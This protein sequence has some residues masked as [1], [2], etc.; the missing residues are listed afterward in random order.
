MKT[1]YILTYHCAGNVGA[2]LQCYALSTTIEKMGYFPKVIDFRPSKVISPSVERLFW[3]KKNM[4]SIKRFQWYFL[5]DLRYFKRILKYCWRKKNHYL[6]FKGNTSSAFC[7]FMTKKLHLT[8]KVYYDFRELESFAYTNDIFIVGSDQ[9][10]NPILSDAPQVYLLDFVKVGK[11]NAYGASFGTKSIDEH[12]GHHLKSSLS[13]Y[14]IISVRENSG[15]GIVRSA[16]EKLATCVVDPVFL[17]DKNDWI[18]LTY[19]VPIS[20]PFIFVYRTEENPLFQ[21]EIDKLRNINPQLKIVQFDSF[22]GNLNSDYIIPR[23]GPLDFISY[24]FASSYVLTNSF[25]GSA[26]SII[27]RKSAVIIPH[28]FYNER[29]DSLMDTIGIRNNTDGIYLLKEKGYDFFL[30]K[31]IDYSLALIRDIC[32]E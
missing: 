10:W 24:L 19:K 11:K 12:F 1:I 7:D 9:V 26:F 31:P 20:E 18:R 32:S 14:Q 28:S 13:T 23:K 29:I 17:L 4:T 16:A 22:H 6:I 27:A 8:D 2:M 3:K 21:K 25:H 15:I 5:W 30:N